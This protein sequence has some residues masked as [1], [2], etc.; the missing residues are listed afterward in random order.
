MSIL[1]FTSIYIFRRLLLIGTLVTIS[2]PI[3]LGVVLIFYSLLVGRIRMF[4]SFPWFFYLL[5]LVFLGGVIVLV[6]Y[7]RTLSANEK[8]AH[9]Y[10][11]HS[12]FYFFTAYTLRILLFFEFSYALKSGNIL[13]YVRHVYSYSN[14]VLTIFLMRYLLLTM[15]RVVKLVKFEKG[16]LVGRL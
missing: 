9:S 5:V 16:P 1:I 3:S 11:N 7:I 4:F 10:H 12:L 13:S 2:H 15:V 14:S 6:I 8:F